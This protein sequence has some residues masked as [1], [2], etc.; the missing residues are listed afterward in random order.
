[1]TALNRSSFEPRGGRPFRGSG[2]ADDSALAIVRRP[3][4]Y[5]RSIAW[6]GPRDRLPARQDVPR[7]L[8]LCC[9][10]LRTASQKTRL[11][12]V[13]RTTRDTRC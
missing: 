6:P 10:S 2:Q 9:R 3:T 7:G 13:V 12:Q 5:F 1:M 8:A 11:D 4:W